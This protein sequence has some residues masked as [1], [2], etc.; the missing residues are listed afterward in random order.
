MSVVAV[1]DK[2][3][4]KLEGLVGIPNVVRLQAAWGLEA[5][6]V[7]YDAGGTDALSERA[8]DLLVLSPECNKFSRRRHGR[9]NEMVTAGAIDAER[10]LRAVAAGLARVVVVENVDEPD[11]VA[12]IS[13]VLQR[14]RSYEWYSQT[15]D[16]HV[17]AACPVTRTRRYWVGVSR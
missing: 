13:T 10:A 8:V 2:R 4:I 12:A 9:D 11:G 6:S 15:L 17:H 3:P 1:V 14:A 16:P 7:Y 5:A